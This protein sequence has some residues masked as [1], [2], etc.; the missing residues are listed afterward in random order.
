MVGIIDTRLIC[1]PECLPKIKRFKKFKDLNIHLKLKHNTRY[2]M[3][4]RNNSRIVISQREKAKVH[5]FDDHGT[6]S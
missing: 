6:V 5:S 2:K 3:D 4:L 1:C